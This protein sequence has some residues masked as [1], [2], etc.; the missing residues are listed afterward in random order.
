MLEHPQLSL[1]E[2]S[3]GTFYQPISINSCSG[4][5]SYATEIDFQEDSCEGMHVCMYPYDDIFNC[6]YSELL[7][8]KGEYYLQ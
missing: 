6:Y 3:L 8:N 2:S 4:D 7:P 1:D 5:N